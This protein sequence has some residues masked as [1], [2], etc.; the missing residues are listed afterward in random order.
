MPHSPV[1]RCMYM[2]E[3]GRQFPVADACL[4]SCRSSQSLFHC[5]FCKNLATCAVMRSCFVLLSTDALINIPSTITKD[6]WPS[7]AASL[8][9]SKASVSIGFQNLTDPLDHWVSCV[10]KGWLASVCTFS[11]CLTMCLSCA[12]T[13][14]SSRRPK[15]RPAQ[16]GEGRIQ[17]YKVRGVYSPPRAPDHHLGVEHC[18]LSGTVQNVTS[19]TRQKGLGQTLDTTGTFKCPHRYMVMCALSLPATL[20]R[21]SHHA[22]HPPSN[23]QLI[24]P[25]SQRF[26]CFRY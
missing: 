7:T 15:P 3:S 12:T 11:S 17:S 8:G 10:H 25:V 14:K 1:P 21:S 26:F 6:L 19:H 5:R 13:Q 2:A 9:D 20:T 16:S 4:T 18:G 23:L 24:E 22:S